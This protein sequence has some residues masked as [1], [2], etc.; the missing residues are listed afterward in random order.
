MAPGVEHGRPGG[1]IGGPDGAAAPFAAT[2]LLSRSQGHDRIDDPYAGWRAL[3]QQAP[4]HEL[5]LMAAAGP[6]HR[7][8]RALLQGGV[9]PPGRCS[10]GWPT[11]CSPSST[12]GSTRSPVAAGRQRRRRPAERRRRAGLPGRRGGGDAAGS[13]LG[14]S[15]L[16]Q[17]G[18]ELVGDG[19]ELGHDEVAAQ[20][21]GAVDDERVAGDEGGVGR[22]EPRDG[23]AEL[24]QLAEAAG[25]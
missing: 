25:G 18:G 23:P 11:S 6:G 7:R 5:D 15:G 14:A 9:L 16:A 12:D 17:D 21:V 1:E 8:I 10:G 24:V 3:R 20:P 13:A 19:G 4:V 22:A 2:Q